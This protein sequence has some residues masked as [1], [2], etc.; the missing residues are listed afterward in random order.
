MRSVRRSIRAPWP[1]EKIAKQM[2]ASPAAIIAPTRIVTTDLLTTRCKRL[3]HILQC[4]RNEF[5]HQFVVGGTDLVG[6]AAEANAALIEQCE[7]IA[8]HKRALEVMS[9]H[10]RG[11]PEPR[12][13]APDQQI[14][15]VRDDRI[16]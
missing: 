15:L 6:G 2:I 10:H 7:A 9:H 16:E 11:E 5:P 3:D 4:G 1:S 12:L 13:E 8:N 14:D